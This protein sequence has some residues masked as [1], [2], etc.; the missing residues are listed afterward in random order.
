MYIYTV[1]TS[2]GYPGVHVFVWR[3]RVKS[4]ACY[5]K[6]HAVFDKVISVQSIVTFFKSCLEQELLKQASCA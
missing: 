1:H 3:A 5:L 6:L 2:S 4:Q